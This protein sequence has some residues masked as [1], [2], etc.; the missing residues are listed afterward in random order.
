MN[1]R[2]IAYPVKP[3]YLVDAICRVRPSRGEWPFAPYKDIPK[4]WDRPPFAQEIDSGQGKQ[5]NGPSI[6]S[7]H[8]SEGGDRPDS[9]SW[10]WLGRLTRL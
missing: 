2:V 4:I 7:N 9:M 8:Q 1:Y 3:G 5:Y 6:S 10:R